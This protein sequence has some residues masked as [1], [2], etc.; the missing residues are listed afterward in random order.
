MH[1]GRRISSYSR[2]LD[3]NLAN[4]GQP[5]RLDPCISA[6][7][8]QVAVGEP[9]LVLPTSR[10][11]HDAWEEVVGS[12]EEPEAE[13]EPVA[14]QEPEAEEEQEAEE[15]AEAEEAQSTPPIIMINLQE[16]I[17]KDIDYLFSP[18]TRKQIRAS[19]NIQC[20]SA[21]PVGAKKPKA[22]RGAIGE[23]GSTI[24]RAK[25]KVTRGRAKKRG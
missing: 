19:Y 24:A 17:S 13:E 16:T 8:E 15:G 14:E 7:Q 3:E 9:G 10:E 4:V 12:E 20:D 22:S 1:Y 23:G 6:N 18:V 5:R 11:I 2:S 21:S 25:S